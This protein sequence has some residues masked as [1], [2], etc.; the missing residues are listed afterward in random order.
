[1]DVKFTQKM[2]A[3]LNG[4]KVFSELHYR[5]YADDVE[6]EIMR[7]KRT[8]GGPKYLITDD[9][10]VSGSDRFDNFEAGG[11]GL[12]AWLL[13][14]CASG[15][16]EVNERELA[17]K[18]QAQLAGE[19]PPLSP[20][21]VHLV[22]LTRH[23]GRYRFADPCD[24]VS[25]LIDVGGPYDLRDEPPVCLVYRLQEHGTWTGEALAT[26]AKFGMFGFKDVT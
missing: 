26:A 16:A 7:Y 3:H 22:R 1:M 5:I 12:S 21:L 17:E 10:F 23:G 15:E 11:V 13:A 2:T 18:M 9:N 20:D 4:G 19:T 6:T 8:S 24:P 25:M 14:H